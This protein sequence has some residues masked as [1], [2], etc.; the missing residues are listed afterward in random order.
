MKKKLI[1]TCF[2][3]SVAGYLIMSVSLFLFHPAAMLALNQGK[4]TLQMVS[5]LTFWIG[6][7]LGTILLIATYIIRKK[8]APDFCW[9]LNETAKKSFKVRLISWLIQTPMSLVLIGVFLVGLIGSVISLIC[10]TN[11]S[12]HTFAFLALTLLGVS[13]YIVFNNL[14]FAYIT[15]K[16]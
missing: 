12:Y 2:W 3:G 15:A 9:I 10:S 14:N 6:F 5:S 1:K 11:S 7:L 8:A 4:T 13:E 16:E